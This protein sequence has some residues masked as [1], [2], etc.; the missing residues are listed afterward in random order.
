MYT[1]VRLDLRE[2]NCSFP[3]TELKLK[4]VDT[5]IVHEVPLS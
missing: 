2:F 5:S 3:G 1:Q 4:S